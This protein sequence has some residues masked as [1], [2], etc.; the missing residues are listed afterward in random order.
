MLENIAVK[1]T[2]IRHEHPA[3]AWD[4]RYQR[5]KA[6]SI[7]ANTCC[8]SVELPKLTTSMLVNQVHT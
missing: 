1:M 4:N 3:P 2:R 6:Q 7:A 5:R 8:T